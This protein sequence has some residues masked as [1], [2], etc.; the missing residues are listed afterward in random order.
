MK[1]NE[2]VAWCVSFVCLALVFITLIVQVNLTIR[3]RIKSG[4][5]NTTTYYDGPISGV[6]E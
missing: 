6:E 3:Q 5:V 1:G 4:I 2:A